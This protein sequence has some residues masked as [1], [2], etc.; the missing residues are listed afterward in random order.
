MPV[1]RVPGSPHGAVYAWQDEL[2][3]WLASGAQ[4]AD[5]APGGASPLNQP[6]FWAAAGLAAVVIAG[7]WA[8][9]ARGPSAPASPQLT[10]TPLRLTNSSAPKLPPLLPFADSFY[11]QERSGEAG[12]YQLMHGF[13]DARPPV[14][15]ACSLRNPEL[16]AISPDGRALLVRNVEGARVGDDPMFIQPLPDG[17]ARP[18][19]GV[20]GFDGAWTP[21][22]RYLLIS[23][24]RAVSL[25]PS[26]GGPERHLFE[27]P[28]RAF[29]F[30]WSPDAKTL[31]FTL[32]DPRAASYS[33]WETTNTFKFPRPAALGL[34]ED[35]QHCCGVWTP[36]GQSFLFQALVDGFYQLFLARSP[37]GFF[38]RPDSPPI[39]LTS[40][41]LHSRAPVV[42][43]SGGRLIALSQSPR[44]EV[45]IWESAAR[46]W[47][48]LL[49]GLPASSASFSR[50]EQLLAYIRM[51]D[52][53]LWTCRM[54]DCTSPI[55]LTHP[56]A[57]AA[58]PR[59]SPDGSS[60]AFM[61]QY[62]GQAYRVGILPGRGAAP[63]LTGPSLPD[64]ADPDWSPDGSRLLFGS[65][66]SRDPAPSTMLRWIDLHSHQVTEVPGSAGLHSPRWSPDGRQIAAI[67]FDTLEPAIGDPATGQ[68]RTL[69]GLRAG[70]LN[71]SPAGDRLIALAA[72]PSPAIVSISIA[73]GQIEPLAPL[74]PLR[75]PSFA[76]GDW[77][78]LSP[79]GAPLALRDLSTEEIVSW[80]LPR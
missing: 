6:R 21:D 44:S 66:P 70:Y 50:D 33:I 68:W 42:S 56:P 14:P 1:H 35:T 52:H 16:C 27:L 38:G 34:D 36:G 26:A 61:L 12:H 63:S 10:G 30:R 29:G 69:P 37:T 57:R 17:P 53:T 47:V 22:G 60:V 25:I 76:L 75:R 31:R 3:R 79:A 46:R 28:G 48:P 74:G 64:A 24:G 5:A 71:W 62:P 41:P 77:I 54:P 18:L 67:R 8:L 11:Y 2:D 4:L 59:W 39:Q 19:A 43:P 40:G 55:Q 65:L 13:L 45:V 78:G 49:D 58:M 7:L 51:P 80:T 9:S 23:R 15:I 72:S 20:S 32:Y 73:S